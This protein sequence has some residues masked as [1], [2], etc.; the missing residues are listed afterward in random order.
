MP[1]RS[2]C[3]VCKP[4]AKPRSEAGILVRQFRVPTSV[5]FRVPCAAQRHRLRRFRRKDERERVLEEIE[6]ISGLRPDL[7]LSFVEMDP[8]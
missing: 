6:R 3:S 2:A 8:E 5:P 4:C 7:S 1:M